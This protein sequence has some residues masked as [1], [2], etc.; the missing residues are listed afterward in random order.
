[1]PAIAGAAVRREKTPGRDWVGL[2]TLTR[3]L[4]C[5]TADLVQAE[6]PHASDQ[7]A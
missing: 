5:A 7:M 1:M 4:S 6:T 2:A 3:L